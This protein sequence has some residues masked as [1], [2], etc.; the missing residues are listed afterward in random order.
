MKR[1]MI[2]GKDG[3]ASFALKLGELYGPMFH[4][5]AGHLVRDST[6]GTRRRVRAMLERRAR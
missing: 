1:V 2:T 3:P 5:R 6:R 4:N